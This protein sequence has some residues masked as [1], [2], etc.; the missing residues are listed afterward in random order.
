M[1]DL[2]P[3][4]AHKTPAPAEDGGLLEQTVRFRSLHQPREP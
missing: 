3:Q 1:G 2:A 4:V